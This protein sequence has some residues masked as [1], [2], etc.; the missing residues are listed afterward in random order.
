MALSSPGLGSNLDVNSII[1]QLMSLEQR[2]L[3]ALSQK[4][5]SYQAKISALGSLQ[6]SISAL[7]TAAGNLVPATGTTATAEILAL[8]NFAQRLPRSPR[9]ALQRA[10]SPAATAWKSTSWPGSTASPVAPV[11]RRPSP[12]PAIRCRSAAR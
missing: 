11:P 5:A 4:E 9:R 6:G 7:Q 8:Q 10:P 2:P 12:A 1:S 3:T